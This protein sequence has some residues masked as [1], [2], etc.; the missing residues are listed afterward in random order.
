MGLIMRIKTGSVAGLDPVKFYDVKMINETEVKV[1][2]LRYYVIDAG[3]TF[4]IP[5]DQ[6]TEYEDKVEIN[7]R[8]NPEKISYE[9]GYTPPLNDVP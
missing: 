9:S 5:E 1:T 4:M 2:K 6:V 8:I 7:N 3:K